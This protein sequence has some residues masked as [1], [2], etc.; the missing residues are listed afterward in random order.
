M[1]GVDGYLD[2]SPLSFSA[3]T[4]P[5]LELATWWQ[6]FFALVIDAVVVGVLGAIVLV[7]TAIVTLGPS[8][9]ATYAFNQHSSSSGIS[10]AFRWAMFGVGIGA[11]LYF[12]TLDGRGQT[13]GKSTVGIAV[14]DQTTG[15]PIGCMRAFVR[16][17]I[18]L[19]FWGLF[20]IPGLL[21]VLSPL[22]DKKGQ[23][24]HDHAV[25]SVVVEIE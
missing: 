2:E 6:R 7:A 21:N 4:A 18:F 5:D 24:W 22:W 3:S 14:R 20:L 1:S 16:W 23:A 8:A 17:V 11:I 19:L 10:T 13:L 15:L 25:S 9:T 12:V